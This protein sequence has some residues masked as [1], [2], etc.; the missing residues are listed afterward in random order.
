[1]RGWSH[2]ND[3]RLV[4][5][6]NSEG[7][8]I[9]GQPNATG[10]IMGGSDADT[11]QSGQTYIYIAIRRGPMKA[12]T[13]GTSVY[14]GVARSGTSG[15]TTI[16]TGFSSDVAVFCNREATASSQKRIVDRLRGVSRHLLTQYQNAEGTD[17]AQITGF[18]NTSVTVGA[19]TSE[20]NLNRSGYNYINWFFARAPSFMD[21]VCWSGNGSANRVISHNLTVT[22]ELVLIKSRTANN[23]AYVTAGLYSGV[24]NHK[25]IASE[26]SLFGASS[27]INISSFSNPLGGPYVTSKSSTSFTLGSAAAPVNLSGDTYVAYLFASCPGVS[28]VGSYTGNG[29]S[30]TINCGFTGGARF[31]LIKRT[32][33]SGEWYVW[34]T[35]RGIVSANDPHLELSS[36]NAETTTNDSVDPDNTGFIVNQVSATNIN[37][38]SATYIYLAIA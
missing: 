11:N 28:K 12:P 37:V 31:V 19:D 25:D 7:F 8:I 34:D 5:D 33:S 20:W 24:A 38:S 29:S 30:Q 15:V 22:P 17:T 10:F 4:L 36:A 9:A 2:Q 16:T 21:I 1:M 3:V 23:S 27:S 14:T 26:G 32:D 35:A 6:S 18:L 13:S